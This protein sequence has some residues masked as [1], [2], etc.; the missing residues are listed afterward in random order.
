MKIGSITQLTE[1]KGVAANLDMRD[2]ALEKDWVFETDSDKLRSLNAQIM[3][4]IEFVSANCCK[5]RAER[6]CLFNCLGT[7]A[8]NT[9]G[10]FLV[11]EDGEPAA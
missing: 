4:A 1:K 2:W 3:N 10:L 9:E 8:C 5:W 6:K 11:N 7:I